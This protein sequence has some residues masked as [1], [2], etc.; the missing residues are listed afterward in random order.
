MLAL[1]ARYEG[2][3]MDALFGPVA[4]LALPF[5]EVA[6]LMSL[7]STSASTEVVGIIWLTD[8]ST[9]V[10]SDVGVVAFKGTLQLIFLLTALLGLHLLRRAPGSRRHHRARQLGLYSVLGVANAR[11]AL[12]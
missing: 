10:F 4:L 11:F 1:M 7:D 8:C 9:V 12:R 2:K 6:Q 3:W 5:I